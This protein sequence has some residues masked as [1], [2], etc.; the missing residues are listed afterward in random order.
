MYLSVDGHLHCFHVLAIVNSAAMNTG[1]H[2]SLSFLIMV[3]QDIC[4]EVGLLDL[5]IVLFLVFEGT[6]ILFSVVAVSVCTPINSVGGFFFSTPS[7]AFIVCRYLMMAILTNVKV[8]L[9]CGFD[10][11][12]S[13]Y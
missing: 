3:F 11:H 10:V 2:V 6:F 8:I 13:D 7:S 12:F 9:H 4:P 1:V 5:I